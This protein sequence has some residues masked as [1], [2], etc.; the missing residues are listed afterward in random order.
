[1]NDK[2]G[3]KLARLSGSEAQRPTKWLVSREVPLIT[4]DMDGGTGYVLRRPVANTKFGEA[5]NML[6]SKGTMT[7]EPPMWLGG[8]STGGMRKA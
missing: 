5:L 6:K 4:N 3:R 1:M 7:G 8:R 2:L